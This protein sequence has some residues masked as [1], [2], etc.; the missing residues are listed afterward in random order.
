MDGPETTKLED[1]AIIG[2]R[3]KEGM[4]IDFETTELFK[5]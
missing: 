1:D 2:I 5:N 4:G 3:E